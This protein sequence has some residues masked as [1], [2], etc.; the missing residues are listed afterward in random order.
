M[1]A[2]TECERHF[3]EAKIAL[4]RAQGIEVELIGRHELRELAP[5][6][7][8]RMLGAAYCPEEGKINPLVATM[9][10]LA[11]AVAA[12][13]AIACTEAPTAPDRTAVTLKA[14]SE[15]VQRVRIC[16]RDA[17]TET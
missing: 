5:A 8:E 1:V 13:A 9:H 16:H 10:I 12:V 2:E 15:A 3:L 7:S 17:E 11:G 6:L 14:A 4:E